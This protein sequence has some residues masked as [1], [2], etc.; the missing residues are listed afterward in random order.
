MSSSPE[1]VTGDEDSGKLSPSAVEGED[2][3]VLGSKKNRPGFGGIE[4]ARLLWYSTGSVLQ[5][6]KSGCF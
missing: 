1:K 5:N 6:A 4:P 2:R 3:K